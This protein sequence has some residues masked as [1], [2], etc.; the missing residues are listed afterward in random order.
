ML[1]TTKIFVVLSLDTV[2][3]THFRLLQHIFKKYSFKHLTKLTSSKQLLQTHLKKMYPRLVFFKYLYDIFKFI[4][5]S[6]H[7]IKI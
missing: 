1:N 4:E 2:D 7:N 3:S 5:M 6:F